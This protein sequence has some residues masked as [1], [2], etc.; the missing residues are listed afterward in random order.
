MAGDP[1]TDH[2]PWWVWLVLSCVPG[3]ASFLS[4]RLDK[5]REA[6]LADTKAADEHFQREDDDSIKMRQ[7]LS[8]EALAA[9]DR[10]RKDVDDLRT[11]ITRLRLD[12]DN[13][14]NRARAAF[15]LA[16]NIRYAFAIV[17]AIANQR[18]TINGLE[19]LPTP[20]IDMP[21]SLEDVR[22]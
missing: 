9:F 5:R 14:W 13:G 18:L 15:D 4:G 8:T 10:Y 17:L 12:R 22:L 7:Q 2:V 11:E 6:R 1:W 16:H 3:T 19:P 21:A 20:T